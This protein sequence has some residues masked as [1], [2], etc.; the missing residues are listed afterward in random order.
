MGSTDELEI[1]IT[2]ADNIER[3]VFC[4]VLRKLKDQFVKDPTRISE[5]EFFYKK[6]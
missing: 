3:D 6:E 2:F 5:K 1:Y 4:L